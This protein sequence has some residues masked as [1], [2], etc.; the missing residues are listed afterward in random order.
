[1]DD[2][3]RIVEGRPAPSCR[4]CAMRRGEYCTGSDEVLF[5]I[6]DVPGGWCIM[7]IGPKAEE[8]AVRARLAEVRS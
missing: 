8:D 3:D 6:R 4:R 5:P 1:M 7:Y 2:V